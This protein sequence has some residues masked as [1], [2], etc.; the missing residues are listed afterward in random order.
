MEHLETSPVTVTEIRKETACDPV[1]ARVLQN[2]QSGWPDA[3]EDGEIKP[4][5]SRRTEL[6]SQQECLLWGSCVVVPPS[7]HSCAA[8]PTAFLHPWVWP[9]QPWARLHCDYAGPF[10]G[11]RLVVMDAHSK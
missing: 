2:I 5:W 7:L 11:H 8:P 4:V 3:C 9:S 6:S 10:L 1:L